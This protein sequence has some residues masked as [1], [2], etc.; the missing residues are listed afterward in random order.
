MQ[1]KVE[2]AKFLELKK[3][4]KF[5]NKFSQENKVS[6]KKVV[7]IVIP[8]DGSCVLNYFVFL[9]YFVG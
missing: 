6:K 3:A 2:L 1:T 7:P 8:K 9:E 4:Q 5:I